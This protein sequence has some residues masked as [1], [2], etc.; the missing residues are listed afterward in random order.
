VLA[1]NEHRPDRPKV[2]LYGHYDVQPPEP[3]AGWTSPPFEPTVRKTAAGTDAIYAR[4]AAD[5]KGQIWAHIEAIA[6]WQS[7]AGGLPVNLVAVFEGEEEID[8]HHLADFL[9]AHQQTLAADIAI[10]SDTNSFARGKPAITTG[11][12]GLVYSEITLRASAND[13]HS[14]IHGGAVRNPAIALAKLLADLHDASGRITLD[15]FYDEVELPTP[16]ERR[17]WADLG[18]DER[19]Y[20]AGLSLVGGE[21]TLAGEADF[22]TLERKW[23]RPTCDICGITSGYQ[24]PGAKTI[25]PASAS[26]KVSFRLVARQQP[27]RVR[28]ALEKFV[29]D[30]CPQGLEATFFHY[31]AA[32]AVS[33]DHRGKW[34]SVASEAV[35]QG[36]GVRPV[37]IRE[38]L[39]IPIVNLLKH[40]LGLD[41]ILMGFG[42]PDDNPHAPD[43]KFDLGQLRAGARTAAA[44]YGRA[45]TVYRP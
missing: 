20:A 15:G 13:L 22:T 2:L 37:F 17:M 5:D 25:I 1:Q 16:S 4:G 31:A 24:G 36:F 26:A 19:A 21:Q 10:I 28:A 35:A 44:F 8:S 7:V 42:L 14:G 32:P 34:A 11:L 43:E 3:L 27:L 38:G 12:R 29:H 23:S 39:T 30:R 41:T 6:A 9:T 33:V 18:F 45:A 40:K